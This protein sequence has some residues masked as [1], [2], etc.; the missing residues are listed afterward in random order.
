MVFNNYVSRYQLFIYCL[1]LNPDQPFYLLLCNFR[2]GI[3]HATFSIHWLLVRFCRKILTGD[4]RQEERRRD[5]C[6]SVP[7]GNHHAA[8]NSFSFLGFLHLN[9]KSLSVPSLG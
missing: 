1:P 9:H 3:L 6:L 2:A 8:A 7:F 4:Q 5:S